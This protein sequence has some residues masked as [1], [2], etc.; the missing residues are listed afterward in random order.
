LISYNWSLWFIRDKAISWIPSTSYVMVNHSLHGA[1]N[2]SP[3][4]TLSL[5]FLFEK[6]AY[7]LWYLMPLSTIF[8]IY[9]GGQF[10]WWRK[11]GYLEKT[12]DLS[13][14]NDKLYHI[15]LYRVYLAWAGFELTTLV[16]IGT[17]CTVTTMTSPQ[18]WLIW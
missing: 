1:C 13:Q 12:T 10:Y 6:M 15:M 18:I 3:G 2:S 17:D 14:V 4:L 8:Q 9:G 16:V 11:R 7:G 5:N